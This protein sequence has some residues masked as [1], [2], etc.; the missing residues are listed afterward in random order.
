MSPAKVRREMR[1]KS[2]SSFK[3]IQIL[4]I[5]L[6]VFFIFLVS[7]SMTYGF[8]ELQ[9]DEISKSKIDLPIDPNENFFNRATVLTISVMTIISLILGIIAVIS[10]SFCLLLFSGTSGT[11]IFLT[12][13]LVLIIENVI[14][15][16]TALLFGSMVVAYGG[17]VIYLAHKINK[18]K[19]YHRALGTRATQLMEPAIVRKTSSRAISSATSSSTLSTSMPFDEAD[20]SS[21]SS[22]SDRK[23][24]CCKEMS[25]GSV[26]IGLVK[27]QK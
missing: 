9:S 15:L 6:S 22:F 26:D 3:L 7:L 25:V 10:S 17:A 8:K 4:L 2:K 13:I 5:S 21:F 19:D 20:L 12:Q 18:Y 27:I 16:F 14:T 1:Q 11:A 23:E 24:L